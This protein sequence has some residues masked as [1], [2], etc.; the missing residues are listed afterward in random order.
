[1]IQ[2][3]KEVQQEAEKIECKYQIKSE[4]SI[5]C[6]NPKWINLLGDITFCAACKRDRSHK[7]GKVRK[8]NP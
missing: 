8:C 6:N 3:M 7:M 4:E 1:M 2:F 5:K